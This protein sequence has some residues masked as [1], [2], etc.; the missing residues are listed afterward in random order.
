M[1][2]K[3]LASLLAFITIAF[4]PAAFAGSYGEVQLAPSYKTSYRACTGYFTTA[5]N[6]NDV[7]ILQGSASKTVK[8]INIWL[9]QSGTGSGEAKYFVVKRSTANTGGTSTTATSV[10]LDSA[11][12]A[13]SVSG[14]KLYTANPTVGTL[15]GTIDGDSTIIPT[16]VMIAGGPKHLLFHA[17]PMTQA[18]TLRGT[19]EGIAVNFNG[20]TNVVGTSVNIIYDWTEE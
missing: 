6:A 14:L 10:P 4:C 5:A 12:A 8:V 2:H 16:G 11:S 15:V 7:T 9:V 13:A 20:V 3:V 17:D 1:L 19:A 18:G